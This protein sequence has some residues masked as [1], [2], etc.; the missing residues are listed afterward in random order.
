MHLNLYAC[1]AF[2]EIALSFKIIIIILFFL[3]AILS[4]IY[5]IQN[6]FILHLNRMQVKMLFLN[7]YENESKG[8]CKTFYFRFFLGTSSY[9]ML[10]W[11]VA[12]QSM[13]YSIFI[14]KYSALTFFL[15]LCSIHKGKVCLGRLIQCKKIWF[16]IFLE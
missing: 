9:F 4:C 8:I 5:H 7:K 1:F 3:P 13:L 2:Y 12:L 14:C 11:A 15:F 10:C 6:F 16:N